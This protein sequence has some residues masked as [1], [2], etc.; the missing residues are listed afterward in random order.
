MLRRLWRRRVVVLG[1]V[2][3]DGFVVVWGHRDD[4]GSGGNQVV[5]HFGT[6]WFVQENVQSFEVRHY[7]RWVSIVRQ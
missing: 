7:R 3:G 6:Y 1:G 2:C 5:D 4:R